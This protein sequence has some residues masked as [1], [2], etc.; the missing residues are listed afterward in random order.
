MAR[1]LT[2]ALD[3][4]DYTASPVKVD[5]RKLY[6]W[7]QTVALDDAGRECV[8]AS[9]DGSGTFIIPAGGTGLGVLTP[10]RQWVDRAQ[11]KAVT[12]DGGDAPMLAS[13]FDAP[14]DLTRQVSSDELLD[15]NITAVYELDG[16]ARLAQALGE[17]IV[18][19]EYA[20]RAGYTSSEAFVLAADDQ[21]FMLV[22][23]R[24]N[25]EFIGLTQVE[26]LDEDDLDADDDDNDSD[27]IDF[28][29]F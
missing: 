9:M 24:S 26:G 12:S 11:L 22:G 10:Q 21:A 2:F 20:Y 27:D 8:L 3:G 15:C 16:G 6:G 4:V 29:M 7:T 28:S 18:W 19:F 14:V 23:Y 25:F 17:R 1:A 13:S 5:R